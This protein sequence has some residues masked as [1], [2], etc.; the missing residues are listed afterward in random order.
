MN[1]QQLKDKVYEELDIY[2]S[3][4]T[5][6]TEAEITSYINEAQIEFNKKSKQYTDV[7]T[8][9]VN[10]NNL[11]D[12]PS[13]SM[14]IIEGWY[15]TEYEL[16]LN[17]N[18][19]LAQ[20]TSLDEGTPE[21]MVIDKRESQKFRLYPNATDTTKTFEVIYAKI[22]TD[23]SNDADEPPFYK[24]SHFALVD[25]ALYKC[26]IREGKNKDTGKATFYY[27]KFEHK[28]YEAGSRDGGKI[29]RR[30][31]RFGYEIK[32]REDW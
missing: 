20:R 8:Y 13:N 30:A 15:D 7:E 5:Y 25:Y 19:E 10:S 22:P 32:T 6:W 21:Y 18:Q 17:D 9:T 11:Y 14:Y 29:V 1:L 26:W 31:K 2:A 16:K 3:A 28:C 4:P 27:N 24:I 12:M 23:L